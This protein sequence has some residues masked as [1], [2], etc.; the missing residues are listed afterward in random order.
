MN[1]RMSKKLRSMINLDDNVISKRVYRRLKKQYK[2]LSKD[3]RPLFLE[4]VNQFLNAKRDEN[5]EG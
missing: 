2:K 3:A 1:N 4:E 5:L